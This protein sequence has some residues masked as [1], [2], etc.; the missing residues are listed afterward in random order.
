MV[1]VPDWTDIPNS[2]VPYS[3]QLVT[4]GVPCALLHE[5]SYK[6][7]DLKNI[8]VNIS[9]YLTKACFTDELSDKWSQYLRS[10]IFIRKEAPLWEV[11]HVTLVVRTSDVSWHIFK[12]FFPVYQLIR[13]AEHIMG[14]F[15]GFIIKS[16]GKR[17]IFNRGSERK[18]V[19]VR[20]TRPLTVLV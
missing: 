5:R 20:L 11:C 17:K 18:C 14:K 12:W 13:S 3:V 6:R 7:P 15:I 1:Y 4:D 16:S 10:F 8:Y 9:N 2:L 19:M